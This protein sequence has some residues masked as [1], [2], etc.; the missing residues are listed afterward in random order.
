MLCLD[1]ENQG[2]NYI[3]V[4]LLYGGRGLRG[5][6]LPSLGCDGNPFHLLPAPPPFP[7]PFLSWLLLACTVQY[8]VLN[9]SRPGS[10]L[11]T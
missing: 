9:W 1:V 7:S 11:T 5:E 10:P 2:L 8:D 3:E 6:G 4:K